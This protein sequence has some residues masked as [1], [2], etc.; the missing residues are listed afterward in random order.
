MASILKS[1]PARIEPAGLWRIVKR[2]LAKGPDERPPA[3]E[4]KAALETLELRPH[5]WRPG[6]RTVAAGLTAAVLPA[7]VWSVLLLSRRE[8]PTPKRY[9]IPNAAQASVSPDGSR[10]S[11][12]SNGLLY[13]RNL[14]EAEPRLLEGTAMNPMNTAFWSPDSQSLAY[15]AARRLKIVNVD[16]GVTRDLGPLDTAL[17]GAWG[18]DGTILIGPLGEGIFRIPA[19]GGAFARVT[20]VDGAR[21]ETRHMSPQFLPGG[22]RFLFLAGTTQARNGTIYA[23]SLDNPERTPVLQADS[24]ARFVPL[25]RDGT[26]GYLIYGADGTLVAAP[27]DAAA[28]RISGAAIEVARGVASTGTIGSATRVTDFSATRDTIAWRSGSSVT[29]ELNWMT[30]LRR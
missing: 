17:P 23:A 12:R 20:T 27:F 2:C 19:A 18:P 11:Y 1:D 6:P 21:N 3:A 25:A 10:V 9:V 13:V 30:A 7:A 29:V 8:P 4:L 28:A 26:Q 15:M 14:N 5:R 22:R 24:N 16:S